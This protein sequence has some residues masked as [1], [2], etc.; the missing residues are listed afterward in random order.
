MAVLPDKYIHA[1]G[2]RGPVCE[3]IKWW[4][5]HTLSGGRTGRPGTARWEYV[6]DS[7]GAPATCLSSLDSDAA[8]LPGKGMGSHV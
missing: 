6:Y 2:F 5:E 8:R 7:D 4:T 3:T 1:R